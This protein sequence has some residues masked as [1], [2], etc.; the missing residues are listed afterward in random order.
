MIDTS[1]NTNDKDFIFIEAI[2]RETA[3]P[4]EKVQALYHVERAD[5]ELVAR[6]KTFIP[7][8]THRR[9]RMKLRHLHED[10]DLHDA[11]A[12]H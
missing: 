5:L 6:I 10:D 3:L 9:V 7:V 8:L 2:A 4:V 1:K 11:F 12:T